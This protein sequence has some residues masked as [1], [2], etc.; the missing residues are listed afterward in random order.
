[1]YATALAKGYTPDTVVFDLKT[2]FSSYCNPEDFSDEPPCY[3][4]ENF[5]LKFQGPMTLRNAIAQ[6]VNVPSVKFLYLAGVTDSLK[7]AR[8]MG[9]TTLGDKD[10]YG[11][12][13]VLGGGEVNL[14]EMTGA[15]GVFAND[16]IRN[17]PTG[18][19]RVENSAGNTLETFELKDTRVLDVQIARQMNDILSDNVAR[20]PEFG[21]DSPLYFPGYFVA[22]KTGTTNDYHDAW[23]IGYTPGIAIGAWAGNNDNSPMVKKIAAFIVAPMWHEV[24][25]YA[26][27]KYSSSGFSPPAPETELDS[28]PPVLKGNWNAD[29]SQG[30]HDILYWADKGNPRSGRLGNPNSDPQFALWEYPVQ[31]WAQGNPEKLSPATAYPPAGQNTAPAGKA[32]A[33]ISPQSGTTIS[34]FFAPI[35]IEVSVPDAQKV[36]RVLYYL[37]GIRVGIGVPPSYSISIIPPTHGPV[38]LRAVAESLSGNEERTINFTIQ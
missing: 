28:L 33:I 29:P 17:P 9:I 23:I 5:D 37:N 35:T 34:S 22:A 7:T 26:I 24:T 19:L 11:L 10:Q 38:T 13:L 4:P 25:A 21:A 36:V 14:L 8:D 2:Q 32:F 16:G 15:Y 12:T 18:I 27:D 31:L 20:T 6:S 30:I 3:S 1:M